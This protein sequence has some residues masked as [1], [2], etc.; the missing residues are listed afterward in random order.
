MTVLKGIP[1]VAE[2]V[3]PLRHSMFPGANSF[4]DTNGEEQ[5]G[6]AEDELR[7]HHKDDMDMGIPAG[8]AAVQDLGGPSI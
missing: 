5:S 4:L 8:D 1:L 6:K 7:I 3:A 2:G